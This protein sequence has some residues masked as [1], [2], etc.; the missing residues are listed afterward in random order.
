MK[1]Y[2][3]SLIA[4]K[5]YLE[6]QK[7]EI[8]N[9]LIPIVKELETLEELITSVSGVRQ[10][11]RKASIREKVLFILNEIKTGS[12]QDISKSMLAYGDKVNLTSSK[13]TCANMARNGEIKVVNTN[14]RTNIYSL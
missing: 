1:D 11:P 13:I 3:D 6:L 12:F 8:E 5:K 14:G 9:D 10:Y 7:R 4:R 2:L